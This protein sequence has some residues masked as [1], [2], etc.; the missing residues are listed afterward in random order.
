MLEIDSL[1]KDYESKDTKDIKKEIYK[2]RKNISTLK[3]EIQQLKKNKDSHFLFL[4]SK[5]PKSKPSILKQASNFEII[6][7]SPKIIVNDKKSGQLLG[8]DKSEAMKYLEDMKLS[9]NTMI[10]NH[11]DEVNNIQFGKPKEASIAE[12]FPK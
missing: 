1:L 8:F 5:P 4:L 7:S 11:N 9:L 3:Y 10:E 12:Y 6:D 2:A